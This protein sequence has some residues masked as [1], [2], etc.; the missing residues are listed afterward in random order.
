MWYKEW[1]TVRFKL[2]LMIAVYTLFGGAL[3]LVYSSRGTS[4]MKLFDYWILIGGVIT[5]MIGVLGG[6]DTFSDEVGKN[7]L[8]FLLTRPVSRRK[9]FLSKVGLY[10]LGMI[11][12]YPLI[13]FVIFLADHT[14]HYFNN[15]GYL[16]GNY[17]NQEFLGVAAAE[18][19]NTTNAII[20]TALVLL[21]GLGGL[22][23]STL[24]SI[25][26]RSAMQTLTVTL[27]IL[28]PFVV[29]LA[30]AI[31]TTVYSIK[32]ISFSNREDV[33]DFLRI[34]LPEML[35]VVGLY[36]AGFISFKRKMF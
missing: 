1:L 27:V 20:A 28:L 13:S 9:I 30:P 15:Y 22:A 6:L 18:M 23:L 33:T 7:T 14:P 26:T 12:I 19:I 5:L 24:V 10:G 3:C 34:V 21:A 17:C 29:A 35:L 4:Y 36:I 8:S 11:I 16:N 32:F 2:V 31:Q 25:F